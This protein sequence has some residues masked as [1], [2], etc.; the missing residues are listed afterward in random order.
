MTDLLGVNRG[1]PPA[2]S[3]RGDE[4]LTPGLRRSFRALA[5]GLDRI[6]LPVYGGA[7]RDPLE[8]IVGLGHRRARIAVLGRDPGTKEVAVGKPFVGVGGQKVRA[9]LHQAL[10]GR[11]S[12][13]LADDLIA[14]LGVYWLNTVPYKPEG[15]EAWPLSVRKAAWPLVA[16]LIFDDWEGRDVLCLGQQ[17]FEWFG[18]HDRAVAAKLKAFWGRP[19]RYDV[20]LEV[21]VSFEGRPKGFVLHPLPHPSPLNATWAPK[22]RGILD[23]RLKTLDFGPQTWMLP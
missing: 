21:E 11:E 22:F 19:D 13:G 6:D 14:G 1:F 20:P 4:A 8:P 15:N 3:H 16:P 18:L 9:A 23:A 17:A 10:L 2:G 5:Q 12:T 7:G